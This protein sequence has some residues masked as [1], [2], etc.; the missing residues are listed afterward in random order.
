MGVRLIAVVKEDLFDG[1]EIKDFRETVWPEAEVILDEQK[2]FWNSVYEDRPNKISLGKLLVD[3]CCIKCTKGG[4]FIL[5][6]HKKAQDAGVKM[7][8]YKG[9]G[10]IT[11]GFAVFEKGG[12]VQYA[13]REVDIAEYPGSDELVEAARAASAGSTAHSRN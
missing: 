1:E 7:K 12:R 4:Q 10:L 5:K 3:I 6:Q 13:W 2:V 11:G 9:E 8:N